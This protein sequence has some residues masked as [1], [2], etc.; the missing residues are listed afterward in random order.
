MSANRSGSTSMA[1]SRFIS[2][3]PARAPLC[4]HS[5]LS[6]RKGWQLVCCTAEPVEARMWAKTRPAL[7]WAHSSRRFRSFQ[8]GSVLRNR[9]GVS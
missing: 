2:W 9:P 5:Q 1:R 6:W 7:A 4:I 8:A 3:K